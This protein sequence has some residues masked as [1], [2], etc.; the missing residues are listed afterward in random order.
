MS[1]PRERQI[2]LKD[3][4]RNILLRNGWDGNL[5]QSQSVATRT[6]PFSKAMLLKLQYATVG[7][8]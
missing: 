1:K 5:L 6:E 2:T 3:D 8:C 7:E 4:Q